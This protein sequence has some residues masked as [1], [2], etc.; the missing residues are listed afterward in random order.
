MHLF[1]TNLR[2][3]NPIFGVITQ[4]IFEKRHYPVVRQ[5]FLNQNII[6]FILALKPTEVFHR[7]APLSLRFLWKLL[8]IGKESFTKI[9]RNIFGISLDRSL[10]I[11]SLFKH[12][13]LL[14]PFLLFFLLLNRIIPTR[15]T[16]RYERR[17]HRFMPMFL[18]F[19]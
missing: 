10:T 19:P 2:T 3:R 8:H 18:M 1:I 6:V 16:F 15:L 9:F 12:I 7:F 11:G 13:Q 14:L 17:C 4:K 5:Y